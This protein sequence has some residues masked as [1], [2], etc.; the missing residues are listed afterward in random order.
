[1]VYV[2]FVWPYCL[3]KLSDFLTKLWF[4]DSG[5]NIIIELNENSSHGR[6]LIIANYQLCHIGASLKD[7]GYKC[8]AFSRMDSLLGDL[9]RNLL[10]MKC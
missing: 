10:N 8:L 6:F 1:V 2:G 9:H 7:L 3:V 4:Q 5:S